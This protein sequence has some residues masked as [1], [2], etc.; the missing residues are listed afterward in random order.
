M[1][2]ANRILSDDDHHKLCAQSRNRVCGPETDENRN[3]EV[4]L[5]RPS[6]ETGTIFITDLY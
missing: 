2:L 3:F 6:I 4:I 1:S 5:L